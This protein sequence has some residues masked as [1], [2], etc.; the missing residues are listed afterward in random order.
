M[1]QRPLLR[2]VKMEF[3]L[4]KTADFLNHFEGIKDRIRAFPGCESLSLLQDADSPAIFFTYSSWEHPDA[5][6]AYRQSELFKSTWAYVK[7]L[8]DKKAT[9]WSVYKLVEL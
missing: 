1:D 5:L 3:V 9:A 8:F 2:I 4:K 6:E 7:T